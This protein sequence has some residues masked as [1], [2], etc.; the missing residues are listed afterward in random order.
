M[1][2]CAAVMAAAGYGAGAGWGGRQV[3]V[4]NVG[5]CFERFVTCTGLGL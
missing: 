5:G 3:Y 4:L 2:V 1:A